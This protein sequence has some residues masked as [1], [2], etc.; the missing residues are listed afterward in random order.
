MLELLKAAYDAFTTDNREQFDQL[1]AI[2]L[3]KK[4]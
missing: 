2:Y 4:E 1:I 3:H